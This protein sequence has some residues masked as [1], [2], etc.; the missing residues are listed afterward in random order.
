MSLEAMSLNISSLL[1]HS[2]GG[3]SLLSVQTG[4][5]ALA[6]IQESITVQFIRRVIDLLSIAL[7]TIAGGAVVLMMVHVT[8]D[9][10]LRAFFNTPPVGTI[11]FVTNYYMLLLVCLPFAYVERINGHISVEVLSERLPKRLT[12]HL[13]SWTYLLSAAVLILVTWA[14]WQEAVEQVKMNTF[15]I[16][17]NIRI[18]IWYGYFAIPLGYGMW[19]LY[20]I[21]K[22]V[23]YLTGMHATQTNTGITNSTGA[24]DD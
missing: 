14:S 18:P 10:I 20:L 4:V 21:L 19:A 24:S 13:Y 5:G 9:V 1:F 2:G 16:D 6:E 12:H 3:G 22:F 15:V 17:R 11:T 7:A 8:G 23:E